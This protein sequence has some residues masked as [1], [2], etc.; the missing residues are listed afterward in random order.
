MWIA[1]V[2]ILIPSVAFAQSDLQQRRPMTMYSDNE[3]NH[4]I[5]QYQGGGMTTYNGTNGSGII[6]DYGGGVVTQQHT[7]RPRMPQPQQPQ[8]NW[9]GPADQLNNNIRSFQEQLNRR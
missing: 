3:G 9:M 7:P 4:G 1:L 5:A 2:L 8:F 6:Q